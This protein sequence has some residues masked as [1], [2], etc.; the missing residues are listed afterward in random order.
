MP[1]I[2]SSRNHSS[3][4]SIFTPN[5]N[6]PSSEI[7]GAAAAQIPASS[8]NALLSILRRNGEEKNRMRNDYTNNNI[9]RPIV[10]PCMF[11][12][13]GHLNRQLSSSSSSS[14]PLLINLS[15]DHQF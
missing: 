11:P 13:N 1:S 14:Q 10:E 7:L 6:S 9:T 8:N 15:R 12:G 5:T 4:T 3:A 2:S